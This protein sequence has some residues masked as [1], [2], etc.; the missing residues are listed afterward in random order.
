MPTWLLD[1]DANLT[2]HPGQRGQIQSQTSQVMGTPQPPLQH[3]PSPGSL[4][5]NAFLSISSYGL[6]SVSVTGD[7]GIGSDQRAI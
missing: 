5:I 6:V 1:E 3:I 2:A 7:H 4:G